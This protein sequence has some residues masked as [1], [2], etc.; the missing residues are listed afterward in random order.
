[1]SNIVKMESD[2]WAVIS[3]IVRKHGYESLKEE[4]LMESEKFVDGQ[5]V[6]YLCQQDSESLLSVVFYQQYSILWGETQHPSLVLI[7]SP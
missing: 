5:D 2:L 7:V 6:L 3:K 4:Q 1:M